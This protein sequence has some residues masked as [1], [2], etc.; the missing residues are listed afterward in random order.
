MAKTAK[1]LTKLLKKDVPFYWTPEVQSSFEILRDAIC[2]EPLLQFPDFSRP[3][4][5]TTD[6]SDFAVGGILSQG[7]VGTDLPV[8]YASRTLNEAEINYST[9]EKE[10]LAVLFGVEHF[11]PYLYGRQFTLVTDHRPL[12]WL[13]SVKDPTSK[14]MRWRIRLNEYDYNIIYKPGR[15][16]ANA[17]ALSRNPVDANANPDPTVQSGADSSPCPRRLGRVQV[18]ADKP[19]IVD[20]ET[21]RADDAQSAENDR[22]I[23]SVFLARRKTEGK[24]NEV[25]DG[26][27]K[28]FDSE[29]ACSVVDVAKELPEGT[30]QSSTPES[31]QLGLS[32]ANGCIIRTPGTRFGGRERESVLD[33]QPVSSQGRGAPRVNEYPIQ[34]G[35]LGGCLQ[36]GQVD[37]G[38]RESWR[39]M[40]GGSMNGDDRDRTGIS[41]GVTSILNPGDPVETLLITQNVHDENGIDA[42]RR[43]LITTPD[44]GLDVREL[45][46][47]TKAGILL[48]RS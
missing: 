23:A 22:F 5:V 24:V 21:D 32:L 9:I 41:S 17:D 31:P 47:P 34:S 38:L 44:M 3:F 4:L 29:K 16:N 45:F 6:A 25:T 37:R 20:S 48:V 8:A 35:G 7:T 42:G 19:P 27:V 14:I 13:H 33:V 26:V 40:P 2:A 12:V 18:C 30:P 15:V 46:T 11:R 36:L 43:I 10:L 1:P 39:V 28:I